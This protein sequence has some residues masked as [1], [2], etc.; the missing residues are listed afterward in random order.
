MIFF[1]ENQFDELLKCSFCQ[2]RF[3]DIIKIIPTCMS[4]ICGDCCSDIF[5]QANEENGFRC[6]ICDV[7]HTIPED[8]LPDDKKALAILRTK[9]VE[10]PLDTLSIGLVSAIEHTQMKV[11]Q[12]ESF[13]EKE[14]IDLHFDLLEQDVREAA[15]STF[16]H[17]A[18]IET[19]LLDIIN[20]K[21]ETLL[22]DKSS[23]QDVSIREKR[24]RIQLLKGKQEELLKEMT[25]Y[26]H[27]WTEYLNHLNIFKSDQEIKEAQSKAKEFGLLV[28]EWE[29]EIFR[30]FSGEGMM[31]YHA[32]ERILSGK[33]DL[34]ILL[35]TPGLD[36][37]EGNT[38]SAELNRVSSRLIQHSTG[39]DVSDGES[40][41]NSDS[42]DQGK[43]N[44]LKFRLFL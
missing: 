33:F 36:Y 43:V 28:S 4:S 32:N 16:E 18:R 40:E 11:K 38:Y 42:Y 17:I 23:D 19:N 12:L 26:I 27:E 41:S 9:K 31:Q 29:K 20:K 13:D 8:G 6:K 3:V 39:T 34:G 21:R 22:D 24:A 25:S 1:D 35:E 7:S 5:D 30:E 14:R 44:F 2:K 10:R 15:R 37:P